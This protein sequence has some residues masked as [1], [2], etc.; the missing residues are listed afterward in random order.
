MTR[1]NAW[2]AIVLARGAA[3]ELRTDRVV[4]GRLRVSGADRAL[5]SGNQA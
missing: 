2:A 4:Q 1:I 5:R 3:E